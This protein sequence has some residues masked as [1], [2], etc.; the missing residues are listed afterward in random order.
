MYERYFA[1]DK[2]DGTEVEVKV[3]YSLGGINYFNGETEARGYWVNVTPVIR[4]DRLGTGFSSIR[5]T[6][7]SGFKVLLKEVGRKS[8]KAEAEANALG[9]E[10]AEEL[11]RKLAEREGFNLALDVA[12]DQHRAQVEELEQEAMQR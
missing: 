5:F 11:A 3:R 12:E 6:L 2:E 8:K 10:R 1:T 9:E 4:E 7:F